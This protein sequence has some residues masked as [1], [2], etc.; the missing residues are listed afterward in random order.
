MVRATGR[1]ARG[2]V[3]DTAGM[4]AAE[5]ALVLPLMVALLFGA[6]DMGTALVIN[7]KTIAASQMMADLASRTVAVTQEEIDDIV[8]AG[9]QAMRPYSSEAFSYSLLS[10]EFSDEAAPEPEICWDAGPIETTQT[11]LDSTEPLGA[12][13]DGLMVVTVAYNY[14]PVFATFLMD[15]ITM[16][17]V[18]FARGRRSPVVSFQSGLDISCPGG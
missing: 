1:T 15:V 12:P 10:I 4:I 16:R 18:A 2:W 13:G 7:Q 8:F 17:E 14:E 6:Y 3:R 11:M 5:F 9:Q